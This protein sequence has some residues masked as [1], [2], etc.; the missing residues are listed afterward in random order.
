[1]NY[2]A[3]FRDTIRLFRESKLLWILGAITL[4][5]EAIFR[6]SSYFIGKPPIPWLAYPLFFIA[7]YFSF[8][9]RCSLIY[10]TNQILSEQKPTFSEAWKFSKTKLGRIAGLYF[11]SI[12]LLMFSIL[13]VTIVALSEISTALTLVVD[14]LVAYFFLGSLFSLSLCAIVMHNLEAGR[15]LW[16]GLL[17]VFNNLFR[18]VVLNSVFLVLQIGLNA[19][20]GHALSGAFLVVPLTVTMSVAYRVFVA[21]DSYP[22]LSNT[23]PTA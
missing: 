4:V 22:T 9:A 10:S 7:L 14:L 13:I 23:Q 15:A 12:P 21:K 11:L 1:M 17:I 6:T 18:V 2:R 8:V 5:S 3:V 16:L 19:L 20:I